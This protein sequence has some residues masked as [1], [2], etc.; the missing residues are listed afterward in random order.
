MK[1]TLLLL[2]CLLPWAV[3]ADEHRPL[4]VEV[5]WQ[6][7]RVGSPVISPAGGHVVVPV[8]SYD[9]ESDESETRL[10][11]LSAEGG[12][13]RPLTA[14][15][16]SASSP[17]FSPDGRRLAFVSKRDDD[18]AG[19]IYVLD[20][21]GPGEAARLT[22]VP[23][24]VSGIKWVGEHL[25]FL[26]SIWPELD[27][28]GMVTRLEEEKN[29]KVTAHQWNALPYA[30]WDHWIDEAREVHLF[31]IP[32]AGGEVEGLTQPL[33]RQLPRSF[34]GADSY[35]VHPA[36]S[37]FVFA[38]DSDPTAVDPKNE[39]LLA[40]FGESEYVNLSA[41]ATSND[42]SPAFSPDGEKLAWARQSLHGFYADTARLIVRDLESGEE[43][44]HTASWDRSLS[45]M[46]WAP[47]SAGLFAV[48][49]DAPNP[50]VFYLDLAGRQPRAITGPTSF[51][52]LSI[53]ADGT[54]VASNQSFL[55]PPRVVRI[56]TANGDI[57]RLDTFN[58]EIL[59]EVD[60]GTYESVTYAGYNG[61]DIQMWVHYPPGFDPDKEYPLF[62]LIHGGPHNAI[63]DG[64][65]F[66]WNAQTFASWGY[67]TAWHN[68]HGSNGF[69]QDFADAINPDWLTAPY[70]DTI[71]AAEWFAEK[72][73]IDEDRMVAGGGSYGGYL[74]SILLGKDHPFNALLIH[75]PVYN[76][77][78][79]MAADFAVHATRFGDF[80]ERPE[81][82]REI[83]PHYYAGEFDTPALIVHGQ[84]DLRVPVGQA[85]ELFRTLQ[86]RG[87]ESRLIYYPDENHWVLKPNN[88]IY[89]YHE[90]RDWMTRF[91]EP[92]GR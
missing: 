43:R 24:G 47:D 29:D 40:A 83:S 26:S 5:L 31:R 72:D 67:V 92:G 80:W 3:L 11:L 23:T 2:L 41:E 89:W 81:I 55:Y 77:Y 82:Y 9:V 46:I 70:H 58:D 63:P 54:L 21:D 64:F 73:W 14:A 1:K 57:Q 90:V 15:G 85:F 10:W 60:L 44:N 19:Q 74:S 30:A 8:T 39:L 51:G 91:A 49:A 66:R 56:D 36:E 42:G 28:D 59:A 65:H 61:Q 52:G 75:A 84:Q 6:M 88:S 20:M 37:H 7:D 35:D 4:S 34:Q 33:G 18:E 78:S 32:A 86:S 71:A 22:E 53:A 87:I 13:Q 17:V 68:F 79:Q 48:V 45:S 38:S 27:W 12:V 16:L 50:R 62:L 76:M 25:Y 69:G